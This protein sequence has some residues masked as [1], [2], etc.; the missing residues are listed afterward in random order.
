MISQS[1]LRNLE[2]D[3]LLAGRPRHVGRLAVVGDERLKLELLGVR[4]VDLHRV[5]L[6]LALLG[7]V[8]LDLDERLAG[9]GW[10]SVCGEIVAEQAACRIDVTVHPRDQEI[11]RGVL[12]GLRPGVATSG[13]SSPPQPAIAITAAR[14]P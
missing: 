8:R 11:A 6:G 4:L 10:S 14:A 3:V 5:E 2:G 7:E 12:R 13:S 1:P 9:D